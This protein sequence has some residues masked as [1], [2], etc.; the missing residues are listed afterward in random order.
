MANIGS[1][2]QKA[3]G[4]EIVF[5]IYRDVGEGNFLNRICKEEGID[6]SPT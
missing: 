1:G 3:T 4:G 6:V 5:I 2:N